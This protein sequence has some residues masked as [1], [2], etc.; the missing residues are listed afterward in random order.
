MRKHDLVIF[1]W[2]GTLQDDLHHI[3]ECGV[4]R[5][6]RHYGLPC[7]TLDEYRH[8]VAAD[9]MASFY[10][11]HGIPA[12][13]T[14]QDLNAI[15]AEGFKE[16]GAP[17]GLFPDADKIVIALALRGYPLAVASGYATAKL[18]AAVARSGLGDRF[19]RVIGDVLDKADAIRKITDEAGV[20]P[21]RTAVIGDTEEDILGAA[22][23]GATAYI[24]PRGFHP[25]SRIEATRDRAP[26]LVVAPT[27][28]D[29]LPHFP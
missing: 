2:N 8:E 5:I 11:P 27:L 20:G 13:V 4:Q 26:K 7:P 6:F 18:D 29:L 17:P 3:Y 19:F 14:K 1:D 21:E 23:V 24:C 9:F 10:W 22:A 12:D 28:L 16:K 15:M 25:L